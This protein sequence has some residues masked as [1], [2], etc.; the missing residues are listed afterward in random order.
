[1]HSGGHEGRVGCR[2]PCRA[3]FSLCIRLPPVNVPALPGLLE[4]IPGEALLLSAEGTIRHANAAARSL[5]RD[6]LEDLRARRNRD[7]E[8]MPIAAPGLPPRHT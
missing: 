6:E 4:A 3:R 5:D 1:M 8:L 2:E 7:Y